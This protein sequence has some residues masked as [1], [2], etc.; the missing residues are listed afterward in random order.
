[1]QT[2]EQADAKG[3]KV[4]CGTQM[5][6]IAHLVAGVERI[7]NGAIGNI[8][9]G[10][11]VRIGDGLMNWGAKVR[12]PE[13][14][15]IEWQ[16]QRWLFI[17]W[18]SGDFI[19]EQHIHNIDIV[20]WVLDA[21]PVKCLG[22]GGRQVRTAP[23]YGDVYDHMAV[24]YEYPKNVRVAYVGQQIDGCTDRCDQRFEGT[25]GS[26]YLDF[27]IAR[28]AGQN[29]WQYEGETINPEI[30]QHADHLAAI[31]DNKPINEAKRVAE[32]TMTTIMG[33]MSAYTGRELSWDWLMKSSKLDYTPTSYESGPVPKLEVAMPGKT[34]LM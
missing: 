21:H 29:P 23:E 14:S 8:V 30:K 11:C 3:L 27:A 34:P 7:H 13:W 17:T 9:A 15:D 5:R 33:R 25:K 19:V 24:E 28:I 22:I 4:V 32:S 10:Q 12:K 20:N 2:A 6:R 31:R 16:I 18:L 1:M 26:S